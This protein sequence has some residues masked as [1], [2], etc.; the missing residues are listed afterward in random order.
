MREQGDGTRRLHHYDRGEVEQLPL[1]LPADLPLLRAQLGPRGRGLLIRGDER[2]ATYVDLEDARHLPLRLTLPPNNVNDPVQFSESGDALHWRE[3]DE[4]FVMPLM[5]GAEL[6]WAEDEDWLAPLRAPLLGNRW[7]VSAASA[8]VLFAGD[9]VSIQADGGYGQIVA[10]RYV[11]PR[12]GAVGLREVGRTDRP[13]PTSLRRQRDCNEPL[14]CG[15]EWAVSP[16]GETLTLDFGGADPSCRFWRWRWRV[17]KE[18]ECATL[19]QPLLENPALLGL[20]AAIDEHIIILRD[21]QR[22]H[23]WNVQS[24]TVDSIPILGAPPFAWRTADEG[25]ALIWVSLEGP[26]IRIDLAGAHL[27]TTTQTSCQPGPGS[28]GLEVSPDGRWAAWACRPPA[29]TT[30][31]EFARSVVV[32]TS[33]GG[34]ERFEGIPMVVLAIDDGGDVLLYSAETGGGEDPEGVA[35]DLEPLS[36]W[37]LSDDRVLR[38]TDTLEPTPE[39]VLLLAQDQTTFIQAASLP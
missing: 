32:R 10:F 3:A 39:P 13:P 25:R 20:V 2:D 16:S 17:G 30:E 26:T 31:Q 21:H 22:L 9:P 38:R 1:L 19:P 6:E 11:D 34:V 37:T 7:V 14:L 24:Q 15:S 8:P 35:P 23:W 28:G 5:P 12:T 27:V 29:E 33:S 36:L 4:L 18:A